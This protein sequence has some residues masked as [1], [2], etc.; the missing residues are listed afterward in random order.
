MKPL[1]R[2]TSCSKAA[3]QQASLRPTSLER[4]TTVG[5]EDGRE[6]RRREDGSID[7]G[8]YIARARVYRSR[9]ITQ[10]HRRLVRSLWRAGLRLKRLITKLARRDHQR[11]NFSMQ[12]DRNV[13][14][15]QEGPKSA[16]SR[17]C[18]KNGGRL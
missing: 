9:A 5:M 18:R 1:E 7:T 14:V 11:P 16:E 10:A 17:H 15:K 3:R 13:V 4:P 2:M 8:Y 6:I 12:V